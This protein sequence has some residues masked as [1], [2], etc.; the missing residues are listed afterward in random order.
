LPSFVI[1]NGLEESFAGV[2]PDEEVAGWFIN[3]EVEDKAAGLKRLKEEGSKWVL[4]CG[5]TE[6]DDGGGCGDTD[7]RVVGVLRWVGRECRSEVG[8]WTG[9]MAIGFTMGTPPSW[10]GVGWMYEV[11]D[12]PEGICCASGCGLGGV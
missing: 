5:R 6:V 12:E 1:G 3:E 9:E 10:G 8:V 7:F 2:E 4:L 11:G